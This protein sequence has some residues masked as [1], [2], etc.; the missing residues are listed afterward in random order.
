MNGFS[1]PSIT[2]VWSA[3]NTSENFI[4]LG[5]APYAWNILTRHLPPGTRSLIPARSAGFT[6]GRLLLV[7]WR[8]PFSQTASTFRP[9]FSASG[10]SF[11]QKISFSMRIMCARSLTR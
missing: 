9:F 11:G 2:P 6:I 5:F 10:S 1:W 4:G 7:I 3:V 8:N